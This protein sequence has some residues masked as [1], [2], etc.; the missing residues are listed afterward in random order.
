MSSIKTKKS[1]EPIKLLNDLLHPQRSSQSSVNLRPFWI[2]SQ[3]RWSSSPTTFILF[4]RKF[5]NC[6]LKYGEIWKKDQFKHQ[7]MLRY[8]RIKELIEKLVRMQKVA[9]NRKKVARNTR[10]CQKVAEQLVE[11]PSFTPR[12]TNL[13]K[14]ALLI[15]AEIC[16]IVT[17]R[18]QT[19]EYLYMQ[20]CCGVRCAGSAD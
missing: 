9:R 7:K 6:L 4:H 5:I 18:T 14:Y 15:S 8:L 17:T 2:F 3:N 10:S 1:N 20:G 12:D 16:K 13:T 19:R 11:S